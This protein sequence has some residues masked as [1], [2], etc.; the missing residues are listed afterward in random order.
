MTARSYAT[1]DLDDNRNRK[2]IAGNHNAE[3]H[4]L[5]TDEILVQAMQNRAKLLHLPP[6]HV[7]V[8]S[9]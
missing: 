8:M 9:G 6:L 7:V 5:T 3:T 1:A 4:P 2:S